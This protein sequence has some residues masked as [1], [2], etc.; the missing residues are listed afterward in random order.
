MTGHRT[1]W[2]GSCLCLG[3]MGT[4]VAL[5]VSP[6]AVALLLV[7]SG[8]FGSLL[9]L[10]LADDHGALGA[11]GRL[12]LL[13]LGALVSATGVGAFVGYASL[14]GPGVLLLCAAVLGG[15]PYVVRTA[16]SRL[17]SVRAP[18]AARLD[19]A[20]RAFAYTNPDYVLFREP[21]LRDLTDEQLCSRWRASCTSSRPRPSAVQLTAISAERQTYLDELERRSSTG[22]AAWLVSGRPDEDPLPYLT[23]DAGLVPTVD[24]DELTRGTG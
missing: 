16:R 14:A 22:F 23:R 13:A 9:T 12:R 7:L 20:T 15:S 5:T 10:C 8:A 6:A 3:L 4:A 24:W 2:R 21:E 11:R 18:L 19:A 17:R 1:V